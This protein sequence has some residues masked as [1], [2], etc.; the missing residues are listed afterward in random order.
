MKREKAAP[1][2]TII[3]PAYNEEE[4]LSIILEKIFRVTNNSYEVIVVDDGS[5]DNST[6]VASQFPC[7]LIKHEV[8]QGKGAAL[9]TGI[10]HARGERIIFIDADDTYPAENIPHMAEQLEPYDI[11]Y[12]SRFYGK[13]NIPL[14]NRFGNFIFQTLVRVIYG[15]KPRDYST[16]LYGAKKQYLESMGLLSK[17]FAIEPEIAIKATRMK[18][19]MLDIPIRYRPR[20]GYAKLSGIKAG[21]AHLKIIL[22]LVFWKG[23]KKGNKA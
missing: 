9:Q 23:K 2:T 21:Y 1:I 22:H 3:V 5:S 14:F 12:G 4:G 11:V 8:N 7:R 18:L 13:E 17:G 6:G 19:R 16:G 20:V 15:F 10:R